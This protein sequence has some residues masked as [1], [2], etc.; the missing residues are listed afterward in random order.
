L[1]EEGHAALER[2]LPPFSSIANPLDA[3]GS[4]DLEA[5]Y[6]ACVEVVSDEDDVDLLAVSRDTP[7][8]VA[9]REVKQS[10]AVAESAV[11]AAQRTRKPVLL[12]SNLCAGFD[13]RVTKKLYE[14]D[15]PYLQGTAE[16]LRAIQAFLNYSE[17]QRR[18]EQLLETGCPSPPTLSWW[19]GR[20]EEGALSEVEARRL[21]DDYGIRGPEER[22]V[23]SADAAVEAARTLGFPVV[24]KVLSSDIQHK[25]EIG[26]VRVDLQDEG[27][28]RSAYT[29]V[30]EAAAKH[31]PQA[32]V[33]TAL[34]QQMISDDAVEVIV[35]VIQDADFGPVVVFGSGGT[36][37]ELFEDSSLRVPPLSR[38]EAREMIQETHAAQLLDG[39]RGAP[40]ADV[41]ALV[42]ALVKVSQLA[43]DLKDEVAALDINPL[44]VL[45]AGE[46]VCAVDALVEAVS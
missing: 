18:R 19:R 20:L 17:F 32:D 36:L 5:T 29:E 45:P 10:L 41:E 1:T 27:A 4:G 28:V 9:E 43:V 11:E 30:L 2:I 42:D 34:V 6:P 22:V 23:A 13:E 14:G 24:L 21:L 46:G 8:G 12:F 16:T 7:K 35:G 39:F 37:V 15:V 3:W 31:H 44:L 40:A 26:G 38:R 33:Q 25:T